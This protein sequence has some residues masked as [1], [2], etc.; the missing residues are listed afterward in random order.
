MFKANSKVLTFTRKR[1][2]INGKRGE[3]MITWSLLSLYWPSQLNRNLSICEVAGKEVFRAGLQRDSN[4]WPLRHAAVLYQ[5]TYEDPYTGGRPIYW[6]HQPVK[7]IKY[8]MKLCNLRENK[9]MSMWP[10]QLNRNLSNCEECITGKSKQ[11]QNAT[12][13]I[14]QLC[15]A[16]FEHLLAFGATFW[17]TLYKVYNTYQSRQV[18]R[19]L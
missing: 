5:L 13:C 16:T 4:P 2:T 6:V 18:N 7:G 19:K 17:S 8:R 15:S 11:T 3:I 14:Y 10:S 1:Q 12:I 9:E